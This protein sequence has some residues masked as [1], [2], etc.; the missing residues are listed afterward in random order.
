MTPTQEGVEVGV[1][2]PSPIP[3]MRPYHTSGDR[4]MSGVVPL[5][6]GLRLE[7]LV[8]LMLKIWRE[9]IGK[10]SQENR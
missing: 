4:L 2:L 7:L 8:Q 1:G 6:L 3:G 5:G 10:F 9:I